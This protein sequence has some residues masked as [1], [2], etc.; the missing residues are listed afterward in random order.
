MQGSTEHRRTGGQQPLP[1]VG[2]RPVTQ[3][4]N[5]RRQEEFAGR[6]EP[7]LAENARHDE[8]ASLRAE[9]RR[10][11]DLYREDIRLKDKAYQDLLSKRDEQLSKKDEQLSKKDE[12]HRAEMSKKDELYMGLLARKDE[13]LSK[14]D[15]P[16][17]QMSVASQHL[18]SAVQMT[19]LHLPSAP[20][21]CA[22][23][24]RYTQATT[25][26]QN[27]PSACIYAPVTTDTLVHQLQ[28]GGD[29]A[30]TMMAQICE[31]VLEVLE[32]LLLT[33][34]RKQRKAVKM[35]C[36]R[37]EAVL[38]AMTGDVLGRLASHE[39]TELTHLCERLAAIQ[40]LRKGEVDM[41]CVA[42]V[43]GALDE[44][45]KCNDVV[46][47]ASRQLISTRASVR[48][49]GLE[50][51]RSL[52]RVLLKES[53][54]AEVAAAP[55]VLAVAADEGKTDR[56]R[57]AALWGLFALGLRNTVAVVDQFVQFTQQLFGLMLEQV[58]DGRVQGK[59]AA[60]LFICIQSCACVTNELSTKSGTSVRGPAEKAVIV[61]AGVVTG[62]SCQ[63]ARY[64]ELLPLL[65]EALEDDDSVVASVA[66][67]AC[68]TPTLNKTGMECAGAFLAIDLGRL[69]WAVRGRVIEPGS[70]VGRW[71]DWAQTLSAESVCVFALGHFFTNLPRFFS[72]AL[73]QDGV[74]PE[75]IVESVHVANVNMA[76][77]LT[78]QD[79]CSFFGLVWSFF[80]I[81]QAAREPARHSVLMP[82][83]EALL[84][85]TANGF[86]SCG[87][88][89]AESA[90]VCCVALL[91]RNE[92]G[93][94]LD[95]AT[96]DCV[97]HSMQRCFDVSPT[98]DWYTKSVSRR[99]AKRVV[100]AVQ[101]VVDMAV[102]DA[103]KPLIL[104]SSEALDALVTAC[105][106]M[107]VFDWKLPASFM[108]SYLCLS[109]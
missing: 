79:R 15:V 54:E 34:P 38:E 50:A 61:Y 105:G 45:E 36:D 46:A 98:A 107:H 63:K 23:P 77:Q 102:A 93:L 4:L 18:P 78:A 60:S 91:G 12:E 74:W 28:A 48:M 92:G 19:T 89:S 1:A 27:E 72:A 88:D 86:K 84:W 42:M 29:D 16:M 41:N 24:V 80:V 103:N 39:T 99:P 94:T 109:H 66:C 10:K 6:A 33:T 100:P 64:Q 83:A 8:I 2:A 76:A 47:G 3:P 97:L 35:Q 14:S 40:A 17:R 101:L 58:Y 73:P 7:F 75:L 26:E 57:T 71:R 69:A 95:K 30:E 37:I 104:E 65:V 51:L 59:E 82:C 106:C 52:P 108:H 85:A 25:E 43:E 81:G 44:L 67:S 11:D 62:T 56:E 13:Q 20:S 31:S 53:V 68:I 96:V 22:H 87:L 49:L 90:A 32:T 55:L 5:M 9:L 70:P 21:P